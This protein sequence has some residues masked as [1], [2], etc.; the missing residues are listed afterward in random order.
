MMGYS[1]CG[2]ELDLETK[3]RL[4]LKDESHPRLLLCLLLLVGLMAQA[5]TSAHRSKSSRGLMLRLS[6]FLDYEQN[7]N[8]IVKKLCLR[9]FE[10]VGVCN[11]L[12]MCFCFRTSLS[13][14]VL[15]WWNSGIC[16]SL[17]S[18]FSAP[19]LYPTHLK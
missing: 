7:L 3:A 9:G 13:M 4:F 2:W 5:V 15:S 16:R 18:Y 17:H 8:M 11:K 1:L 12:C 14:Q 19:K 10:W 6:F